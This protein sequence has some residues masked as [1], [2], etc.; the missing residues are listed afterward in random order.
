[1]PLGDPGVTGG[2]GLNSIIGQMEPRDRQ[3]SPKE[4]SDFPKIRQAVH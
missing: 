4:G 2:G 3:I 1:M